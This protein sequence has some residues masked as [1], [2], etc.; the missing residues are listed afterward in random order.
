MSAEPASLGGFVSE[1]REV[2]AAV[3]SGVLAP[4]EVAFIGGAYIRSG[5]CPPDE[6][7]LGSVRS[8]LGTFRCLTRS[9]PSISV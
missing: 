6:R 7:R 9:S 4:P 1:G 3:S 8:G 5:F 2:A